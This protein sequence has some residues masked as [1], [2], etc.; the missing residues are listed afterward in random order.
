MLVSLAVLK[1]ARNTFL[2][3]SDTSS[4]VIQASQQ[5]VSSDSFRVKYVHIVP[6]S[7]VLFQL[8]NCTYRWHLWRVR[9]LLFISKTEDLQKKKKKKSMYCAW[10]H[11]FYFIACSDEQNAAILPLQYRPRS[12]FTNAKHKDTQFD[13]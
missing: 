6:A 1:D 2:Q 4:Q 12:N 3:L 7:F 9:F 5:E 13:E 11:T 10:I 8:G